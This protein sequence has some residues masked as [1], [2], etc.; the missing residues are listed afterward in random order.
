MKTSPLQ[1]PSPAFYVRIWGL[2]MFLLLLT[3]AVAELDLGAFNAL[4]SMTI[5]VIKM[6][7][8]LLYF[9][10][11]RYQ[12]KVTWVFAAAGFYWLLIMFILTMG[13]YLTRS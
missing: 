12:S 3:W 11:V 6:I 7:L 8:V 4:A 13:D 1:H 9:M 5:A 10:H 2:L